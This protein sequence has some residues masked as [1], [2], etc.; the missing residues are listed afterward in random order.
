MSIENPAIKR[1]QEKSIVL[2]WINSISNSLSDTTDTTDAAKNEINCHMDNKGVGMA[3][4]RSDE[5][6]TY[7]KNH[8]SLRNNMMEKEDDI[9]NSKIEEILKSEPRMGYKEPFYYC[10]ECPKIQNINPEEIKNHL[11]YSKVHKLT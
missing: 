7:S 9:N 2:Q 5:S 11:L 1:V 6:D 4:D 3:S 10:K 8:G